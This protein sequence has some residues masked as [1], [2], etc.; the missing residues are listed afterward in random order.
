[1][2]NRVYTQKATIVHRITQSR[3]QRET[4]EERVRGDADFISS[5]TSRT[6]GKEAETPGAENSLEVF[7]AREVKEKHVKKLIF[8]E[9]LTELHS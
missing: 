7:E 1:M 2:L 5:C 8:K 4:R 3:T 6:A 9:P